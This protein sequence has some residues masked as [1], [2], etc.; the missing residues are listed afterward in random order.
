MEQEGYILTLSLLSFFGV[1]DGDILHRSVL[2]AG[3]QLKEP[4]NRQAREGLDSEL[5]TIVVLGTSEFLSTLR[6]LSHHRPQQPALRVPR[7]PFGFNDRAISQESA[8]DQDTA[9]LFD[10]LEQA[11]GSDSPLSNT[12]TMEAPGWRTNYSFL[13]L[14]PTRR[15]VV[16]LTW[17]RCI[18]TCSLAVH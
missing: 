9:W 15:F 14:F 11:T 16:C 1:Y 4:A 2:Q 7:L 3:C 18:R 13:F 5:N 12:N 6:C 8:R 17:H 10:V